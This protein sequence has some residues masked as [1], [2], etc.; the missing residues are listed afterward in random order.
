MGYGAGNQTQAQQP[1]ALTKRTPSY[2]SS[3]FGAI[4]GTVTGTIRYGI[5]HL[6][7]KRRGSRGGV[8]K[9]KPAKVIDGR[10]RKAPFNTLQELSDSFQLAIKPPETPDISWTKS[11]SSDQRS[12][13][14][15]DRIA[16]LER[17]I[18][19]LEQRLSHVTPPPSPAHSPMPLS[20]AAPPPPPPPPP[21]LLSTS[22]VYAPGDGTLRKIKTKAVSK[23]GKDDPSIPKM[24]M[25]QVLE[26]MKTVKLRKTGV[27]RTA[28]GTIIPPKKPPRPDDPQAQIALALQQ[29][30][31]EA[32]F[33][34]DPTTPECLAEWEGESE[35]L[36]GSSCKNLFGSNGSG[37]PASAS[38]VGA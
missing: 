27:T 13:S 5:D 33:T 12:P 31:S 19:E 17:K 8:S 21:L 24:D 35:D 22:S 37:S 14:E 18:A 7:P 2:L 3:L 26:E 25:T 6:R 23:R 29:R 4:S 36:S 28:D 20:W 30:F 11:D 10:V 9:P 16:A 1:L 38:A 32:L 15:A 34:P